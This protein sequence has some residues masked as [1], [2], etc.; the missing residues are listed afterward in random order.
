MTNE[1]KNKIHILL[2]KEYNYYKNKSLEEQK[3]IIN[4]YEEIGD[5]NEIER[6][7]KKVAGKY[8]P[9]LAEIRTII[10]DTKNISKINLNSSYWYINLRDIKP[11]YD[12]TTGKELQPYKGV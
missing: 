12:I 1:E 2:S 8:I 3:Q 6:A 5:Y 10:T 11:Y 4:S 7:I 9:T